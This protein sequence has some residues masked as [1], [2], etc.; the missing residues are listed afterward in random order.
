M[1]SVYQRW[2]DQGRSTS[3]SMGRYFSRDE[4][5]FL[6]SSVHHQLIGRAN[7]YLDS[8]TYFLE[9]EELIPIIGRVQGIAIVEE[10]ILPL[11][12]APLVGLPNPLHEVH[13]P[14]L[15]LSTSLRKSTRLVRQGDF[16]VFV[17][18]MNIE[19]SRQWRQA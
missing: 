7:M 9:L 1:G 17:G 16:P 14:F 5:P 19:S 15:S 12:V 13:V 8:L 11:L 4:N 6:P 10:L 18:P 2:L 3:F